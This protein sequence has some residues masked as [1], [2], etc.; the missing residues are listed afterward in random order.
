MGVEFQS[1]SLKLYYLFYQIRGTTSGK[2]DL[3]ANV[4]VTSIPNQRSRITEC[5]RELR[6]RHLQL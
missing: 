2:K 1:G 5:C 3:E 4:A 6:K